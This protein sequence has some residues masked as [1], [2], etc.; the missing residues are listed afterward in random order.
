MSKLIITAILLFFSWSL[1]AQKSISMEE[2]IEQIT[3]QHPTVLQQDLYIEQQLILKDAGKKQPF[4]NVGYTFEEVGIGSSGI[5]S[6]YLLQNFNLPKVAKSKSILQEEL[7][8]TG[9]LQKEATQKQLERYSASLYQQILFLKS[10]Q[11]L[12]EYLLATYR[13]I[14]TIAQKRLDA[15][16]TSKLPVLAT[17]TAQQQLELQQMSI[18]QN[19]LVQLEKL[20]QYLMDSTIT[21]IRDTALVV[22]SN[23]LQS[24]DFEAH[25]LVKKID[26][27]I[28]VNNARSQVIQNQLLPQI[29]VGFQTQIVQL[30]YPFFGGQIGV[31]VPLFKKGVKAEMKANELNTRIL[32]QGKIWQIQQLNGQQKIAMKNIEQLQQQ[33]AHVENTIL[34]TLQKQQEFSETAYAIGEL[35]YLNVLQG[36]QQIIMARNSY[37][38]V[39]FQLNLAWINYQYLMVG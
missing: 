26:Q 16:E 32:E 17:Q 28:I 36:S 6:L 35:N 13:K 20:K 23:T 9:A 7:A 22:L 3:K 34:P 27:N 31:N 11:R 19:Y 10:K 14:E 29:S 4:L 12:N 30:Q 24:I 18:R 21:D 39:V 25:P 8:K 2:V 33:L 38:Q 1:N 15:G 37:L 5:H